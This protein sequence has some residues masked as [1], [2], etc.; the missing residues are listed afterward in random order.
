MF[1]S[2]TKMFSWAQLWLSTGLFN[3][4]MLVLCCAFECAEI[5]TR[6]GPSVELATTGPGS[7][8]SQTGLY[9]STVLLYL[10]C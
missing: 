3:T 5:D 9:V 7:R 8:Q 1:G 4:L 6:D 10:I 2:P